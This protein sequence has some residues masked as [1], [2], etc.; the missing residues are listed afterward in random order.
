M[1]S[2]L[3]C[4]LR[5][6]LLFLFLIILP[7][8]QIDQSVSI[9][10]EKLFSDSSESIETQK[11]NQQI[12]PK[13]ERNNEIKDKEFDNKQNTFQRNEEETD[14]SLDSDPVLEKKPSNNLSKKNMD[15]LSFKEMGKA[16]DTD[17]KI[18]SFFTKIFDTEEADETPIVSNQNLNT[19]KEDEAM[20][21]ENITEEE[22]ILNDVYTEEDLEEENEISEL[23]EQQIIA[24]D[25]QIST[26]TNEAEDNSLKTNELKEEGFAFLRLQEKIEKKRTVESDNLVGLL[27]P[28]TGKKNAAG[29]MVVNSLRY[30]LLLKPNELNFKIFDTRGTPQGAISATKDGISNGVKTFIGPIFSDETKEIKRYFR[31]KR[32][33]T[34]FSLSPDLSNV[35]DNI[36]VSGQNHED[37]ISCIIQHLAES[38]TQDIL[39]IHHSDK[40]GSIVKDSFEKFLDSFGMLS[41]VDI[42]SLEI[43]DDIDLNDV[44]KDISQFDRRKTE[45]KQ[46]ITRIKNDTRIEDIQRNKKVKSLERKLTISSPFDSIIVASEG[47]KLL[48]ILSHL[49]FYDVNTENTRIYGTSLWEDTEKKDNV[50]KG[51]FFVTSLKDRDEEFVQSFKNVF[52]RDPMS[53]NFHMYDLLEFIEDFKTSPADSSNEEIFKGQFSNSR[54]NAGLLQRE[55]FLRRITGD[56]KSKEVFSCRLD[57]I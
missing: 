11:D 55:I 45:L 28:L 50:F 13:N 1:N 56:K 21:I 29:N 22:N 47:S 15:D 18:I 37:Q 6:N 26:D 46:E 34:F 24:N 7:G 25:E 20:F 23:N 12:P 19:K 9:I 27:L 44:I 4:K 14:P 35:S 39:L 32:D 17:S 8:C 48:E 3:V 53:F 54:I 36:I 49:A 52:S 42:Q 30:S 2:F 31:N 33:L 38:Q 10:K 51:A 57:E 43:T 41:F 16:R 40:Y 5:L